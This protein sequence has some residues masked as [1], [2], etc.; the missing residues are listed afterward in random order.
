MIEAK[1]AE[2]A[3][4]ATAEMDEILAL[5]G[6]VREATL[7]CT[8]GWYTT[9]R[10]DGVPMAAL[11]GRAG[12]RDEAR[13]ILVR[14]STGYARRFSLSEAGDLLLATHVG[15]DTLSTGH[16]F[17][18][19]LVAPGHRGY[20]PSRRGSRLPYRCGEEGKP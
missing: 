4:A 13:S 12:V 15:E 2:L 1:T 16:G 9:Q 17:P 7:D 10:W 20:A 6:A 11:L 18:L 3:E 8:G 5:G 19:R 14:S